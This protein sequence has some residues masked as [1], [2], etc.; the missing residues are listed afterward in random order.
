MTSRLISKKYTLLLAVFLLLAAGTQA[1]A[2]QAEEGKAAVGDLIAESL[3]EHNSEWATH[4]INQALTDSDQDWKDV[5]GKERVLV[6][7]K[8][9]A[10]GA[11]QKNLYISLSR[12][13]AKIADEAIQEAKAIFLPVFRVSGDFTSKTVNKRS[14]EA[15]IMTSKNLFT[16]PTNI[17]PNPNVTTPQ[18]TQI[19]WKQQAEGQLETHEVY[20]SKPGKDDPSY[21][22]NMD[23]GVTQQLPWGPTLDLGVN[24]AWNGN[25]YNE[26]GHKLKNPRQWTM[27]TVLSMVIPLPWT[28]GFG[29]DSAQELARDISEK[30]SEQS[31]WNVKSTINSILYQTDHAYWNLVGACEA[32]KVAI[33]NRKMAKSQ[34]DRMEAMFADG[35][36]TNYSKLQSEAEYASAKMAEEEALRTMLDSSYALA[37]LVD[38][39]PSRTQAN[40]YLPG[41]E[42]EGVKGLELEASEARDMA[43]KTRP[44][45]KS[46]KLGIEVAEL[47]RD[48]SEN[49]ARPNLKAYT[50]WNVR[51]EG[52]TV[53][54]KT[55]GDAIGHM[56]DP[57]QVI[58]SYS[59]VYNYPLFNRYYDA[60]YKKAK[61]SLTESKIVESSVQNNV[62]L[63]VENALASLESARSRYAS[64]EQALEFAQ[65]AYDRVSENHEMGEATEFELNAGLQRLMNAKLAFVQVQLDLRKATS[66]LYAALGSIGDELVKTQAEVGD[67]EKYRLGLLKSGGAMNF[68][69]LAEK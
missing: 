54:Y 32:L 10:L 17:P 53:G 36:A 13:D 46:S 8:Q 48:V 51:Q 67:F 55:P 43:M 45:L 39:D 49:N 26:H 69:N 3:G 5:K 30:Q 38:S 18:I 25:E 19:G 62:N 34:L 40:L 28:Q 23:V 64:S 47:E 11:L 35:M 52:A 42:M 9:A 41:K 22:A 12:E 57:D 7:P 31:F 6:S 68:F 1:F 15:V 66:S 65:I 14:K 24:L 37:V 2:Q 56:A 29:P 44:E 59:G 20:A 33:E 4:L 50:S 60:K 61:F 21:D 58:Q 63:E 27:G 16:P